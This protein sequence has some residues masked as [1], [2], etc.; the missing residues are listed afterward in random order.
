MASAPGAR[1]A[2][3][4]ALALVGAAGPVLYVG[5]V[6]ALGFMWDGYDPVRDTQSALGAT[7]SPYRTLMNVAG[8]MGL[9]AV[10]LAF[11][12]AYHLVLRPSPAGAVAAGLL[13]VAGVGM[14]VVGFFP[15]DPGCVDLTRTGRLHSIFS[16]PG[17]IGVPVAAMLSALAFRSDGRFPTAWR[18]VSFWLGL[19][20]L[21]SGPVVAL[22]LLED[23]D[24]LLQ[25][26]GMW[27]PLLWI[28]AVSVKLHRLA[29]AGADGE[30]R[31][32]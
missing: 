1:A 21:A 12:G 5:F 15:C 6:T 31:G 10:I 16:M 28:A 7:D 3:V 29:G 26:A 9:G 4:R 32:S 8:F 13:V 18:A 20:T 23:A 25:R 24:G 11:A 30:A 14:V 17:A 2:A 19:V 22:G 27:P